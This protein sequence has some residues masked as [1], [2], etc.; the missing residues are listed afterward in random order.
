MSKQI[1]KNNVE[2]AIA[3]GKPTDEILEYISSEGYEYDDIASTSD[4]ISA[5]IMKGLQ[6]F[7]LGHAD[8]IGGGLLSLVTGSPYEQARDQIR[9][10]EKLFDASNPVSSMATEV[11]GG[12]L[13]VARMGQMANT[14]GSLA[15][16][17]GILGGIAGHGYSESNNIPDKAIDSGIGAV[18]GTALGAATK[19]VVDAAKVAGR[20]M[21]SPLIQSIEQ[22]NPSKVTR[23]VI[24]DINADGMDL[25]T[26]FSKLKEMGGDSIIPDAAGGNTLQLARHVART[27]GEGVEAARKFLIDRDLGQGDAIS[28][29]A[30]EVTGKEGNFY[31]KVDELLAKR[32]EEASP[33]YDDYVNDLSNAVS[34]DDLAQLMQKEPALMDVF[35]AV[36][37]DPAWKAEGLPPTSV[38]LI[39]KVKR[40]LDDRYNE[41]L[42]SNQQKNQAKLYE[43][44]KKSLVK[45]ADDTVPGYKEA[46][47]AWETPTKHMEAMDK[48]RAFMK[49]DVEIVEKQV[50]AMTPEEREFFLY[51]VVRQIDDVLANAPDNADMF[52]R[53]FGSKKK[54]DAIRVA[55]NDDNKFSEFEKFVTNEGRKNQTKQYVL[56]NSITYE[57]G[58]KANQAGGNFTDAAIEATQGN[59]LGAGKSAAMSLLRGAKPGY[60]DKELSD[61]AGIL[62]SPYST[63][64]RGLQDRMRRQNGILQLGNTTTNAINRG[65]LS[66]QN[67]QIQPAVHGLLR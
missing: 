5:Y 47:A 2:R 51:G 56:G 21:L 58:A 38:K 3:N 52:K 6:G 64:Q 32:M 46:R 65:L 50:Q 1:V 49:G 66:L 15:K 33:L 12:L 14:V 8:E 48:G 20:T 22:S 40:K 35:E 29:K 25:D 10:A 28:R 17:G 13:P 53:V 16:T 7:T 39:D 45:L 60:T 9:G 42:K 34:M 41:N 37:K 19:P 31:T 18:T 67:T 27:P 44:M 11:T 24:R 57:S 54:R 62:F 63:I 36:Y 59:Y 4:K 61:L 30:M 55:F 23:D 26:V 43:G